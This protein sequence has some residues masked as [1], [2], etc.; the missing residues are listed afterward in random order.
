MMKWVH[1]FWVFFLLTA[2]AYSSSGNPGGA[3]TVAPRLISEKPK[4]DGVLDEQFW[5]EIEPITDFVQQEPGD[6][7]PA[8]ERTEARIAYDRHNLYFGIRAFDSEPRRLVQSVYERDGFMPA[9]DGIL[10]GIDS[11]NDNR[12][13]FIFEMNTVG[14]KTDIE[15]SEEGSFNIN[16][17]AIW[18]YAVKVDDEGYTI[19]V[20]IPMFV[21][22]FKPA[23]EIEMGLLLKRRIRK[24][25]EEVNWPYFS[26]DYEFGAASQYGKMTGLQGLERGKDLEIKPYGLAGYSQTVDDSEYEA[27]AGVDVKW[28]ITPN[29]TTDLTFNTDFAQIESDELQVN[30]TRFNLFYPEKR[31]FFL[32]SANLFQFGLGQRAEVFF[33]R[34]IGLRGFEEVPII[35]GGRLY[36][37]VGSTNVGALVM[38]TAESGVHPGENFIVGRVK[39]NISR[40]SYLGGI[41][42][43]R[44]GDTSMEDTTFGTDFMALLDNN[45]RIHGQI[46]RSGREGVSEGQW[47]A[48]AGILQITDRYY[49]E[50]RYDDIGENFEPGIG[51]VARPDQRT[52]TGFGQ[53][54][55]RP[56]WSG[57]R[58]LSFSTLFRRIEN[59][60]GNLETR[61]INPGVG[62]TFSTEDT[63][64]AEYED[65][66]DWIPYSFEIAPGI[67]VQ[68]GDYTNR[69]GLAMFE[70]SRSRRFSVFLI[71]RAGSFYGGDLKGF[72]AHV[73][74]RPW[75]Q[76]RIQADSETHWVDLP[77]GSFSSPV[78]RIHFSY[79]FSSSLST[80]VATQYS[81]LYD[82]FLLNFRLR[83]I[84]TP[85]SELWFV[86]NEG[87]QFESLDP[88]L[89]DR[90]VIVKL[91]HNF[92]F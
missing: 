66:F 92:N 82:E 56:D 24:N 84:Y 35:A 13:A 70:S 5:Q 68:E 72:A 81:D 6:G 45:L 19:E 48:S 15:V 49:W 30:L 23:D 54:T 63:I 39:Q 34:R 8:T 79:Y 60:A 85:G 80:R 14:G 47:F 2:F 27:D 17:D 43:N 7:D 74:F 53:Y 73:T 75:A 67:V 11:N 3:R 89:R 57:V 88:S 65:T 9:D 36:G 26:R 18:N 86:Y 16:W 31:D 50:F 77:G 64:Q 1:L 52:L 42:T 55:P 69:S 78:A 58:K 22:R 40:R 28:G 29:L 20:V 90:A 21:L 71:G 38:Q 44:T 4:L 25:N 46:S 83:W 61:T 41:F 33:S 51:F 37:L 32:E 62:I 10:I 12:T 76:V 59:H 91:V 87:R